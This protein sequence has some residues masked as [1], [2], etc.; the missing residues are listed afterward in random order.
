MIELLIQSYEKRVNN[1][2]GEYIL[3]CENQ[4]CLGSTKPVR[5]YP[6]AATIESGRCCGGN[7]GTM[8]GYSR[9]EVF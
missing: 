5:F 1:D 9:P 6:Q 4:I 8:A 2:K 3:L 7:V